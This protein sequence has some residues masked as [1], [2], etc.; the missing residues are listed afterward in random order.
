MEVVICEMGEAECFL[1]IGRDTY[2]WYIAMSYHEKLIRTQNFFQT[3]HFNTNAEEINM[4][5]GTPVSKTV[6]EQ[7]SDFKALQRQEL[8]PNTQQHISFISINAVT[9]LGCSNCSYRG[10]FDRPI[11]AIL[12]NFRDSLY[13]LIQ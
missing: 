3:L 1:Q 10:G 8:P 5:L 9:T 6:L 7:D 2:S 4:Y 12:F 11:Q 13:F